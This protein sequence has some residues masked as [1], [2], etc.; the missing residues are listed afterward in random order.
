MIQTTTDKQLINI[1]LTAASLVA[2]RELGLNVLAISDA[3]VA[4]AVGAARA[5]A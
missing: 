4:E 2:A 5:E 1:C 3:A